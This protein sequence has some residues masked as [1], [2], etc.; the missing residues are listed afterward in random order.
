MT[1]QEYDRIMRAILENVEAST[2]SDDVK[3]SVAAAPMLS[4]SCAGIFVPG[5]LQAGVCGG[6]LT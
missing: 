6:N 4:C 3:D 2:I 1:S 5:T